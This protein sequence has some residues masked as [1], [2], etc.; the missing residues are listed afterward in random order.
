MTHKYFWQS[1][2]EPTTADT[3]KEMA[4]FFSVTELLAREMCV[5]AYQATLEGNGVMTIR[6]V[7]SGGGNGLCLEHHSHSIALTEHA[8]LAGEEITNFQLDEI[9]R[10]RAALQNVGRRIEGCHLLSPAESDTEFL[11]D[12]RKHVLIALRSEDKS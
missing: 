8:I 10:L 7:I 12:I 4:T 1:Q 6:S 9:K 2:S 5:E 3:V 11:E